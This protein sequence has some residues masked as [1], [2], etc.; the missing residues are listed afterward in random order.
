LTHLSQAGVLGGVAGIV[1]GRL[2]NCEWSAER[3]ECP[4]NLA[5][6]DV[7][8]R[9]LAPLGVPVLY[10]VPIGLEAD[11]LTIPLGVSVTMDADAATLC[12]DEPGVQ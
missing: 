10:G 5:L 9:H 6:D 8:D 3:P 2:R 4:S 12:I 1:L 11:T 7:L